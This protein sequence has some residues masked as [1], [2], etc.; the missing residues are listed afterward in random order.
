M[1]AEFWIALALL[2]VA[3]HWFVLWAWLAVDEV[4]IWNFRADE[5]LPY[6]LPAATAEPCH[7]VC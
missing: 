4:G 3:M 7:R 2:A 6:V 1:K 5:R